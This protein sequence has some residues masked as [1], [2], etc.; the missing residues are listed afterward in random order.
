MLALYAVGFLLLFGCSS[1]PELS[2]GV[3]HY[4]AAQEALAQGDNETALQQLNMSIELEPDGWTYF[5]RAKLHRD[6]GKD[7]EAVAD[8]Q[9]G[10]ALD[11]DHVELNW[12]LKELRKP[13]ERRFQG[14]RAK[15]PTSAK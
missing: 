15:P 8:C 5:E 14:R 6:M 1:E 11:P 9:A 4:L 10:L 7:K 2:D 12:L 3:Q 13:A